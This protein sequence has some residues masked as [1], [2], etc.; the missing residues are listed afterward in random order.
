MKTRILGQ[1]EIKSLIDY[2]KPQLLKNPNNGVV[3][4][5]NG[6]HLIDTFQGTIIVAKFGDNTLG[7]FLHNWKKGGEFEPINETTLIEFIP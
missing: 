2:S 4:L 3:I 1:K 5:T 6:R 7:S